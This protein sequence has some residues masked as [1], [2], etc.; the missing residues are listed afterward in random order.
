MIRAVIFDFDG[1]ILDTEVPIFQSWQEIYQVYGGRLTIEEWSTI[2]GG[3]DFAFNPLERL[4]AQANRPL[5]WQAL[6]EQQ[7]LR[8]KELISRQPV[9]PGVTDYLHDARQLGL[10]IGLASSSPCDWV[11]GHL[12]RLGLLQY[13]DCI[14]ASDDVHRTKPD[15]ELYLAVLA[16]LDV[17]PQQA[18][19]LEDSPNGIRSARQAGLFCVAV[20]NQLTRQMDTTH[21]DLHLGAMTDLTLEALIERIEC[22]QRAV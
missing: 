18:F 19:A 10:K 16:V 5:D 13:F 1:L 17:S 2:I 8:E 12:N 7:R 22:L 3:G 14:L 6:A 20:P 11:T 9:M 21:A 4:Q 15:P